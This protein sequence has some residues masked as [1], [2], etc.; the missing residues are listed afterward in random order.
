MHWNGI[1][2][3]TGIPGNS[4]RNVGDS[5]CITRMGTEMGINLWKYLEY[6]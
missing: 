4:S 5:N 3:M 6:F 1:M 2:G